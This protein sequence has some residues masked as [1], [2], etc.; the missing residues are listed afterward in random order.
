ME[1]LEIANFMIKDLEFKINKKSNL[2]KGNTTLFNCE[3]KS[4]LKKGSK[5][6]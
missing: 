1:T 4:G 2:Q 6:Y 3:I 5:M